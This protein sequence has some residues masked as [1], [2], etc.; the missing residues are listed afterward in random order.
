M[1]NCFNFH[2]YIYV[3]F[4]DVRYDIY[5][6]I[7]FHISSNTHQCGVKLLSRVRLCVT[8]WSVVHQ[9]PLSMGFPRPEYWSGLPFPSPGHLPD[10]SIESVSPA[11]LSLQGFLYRR[12]TTEACGIEGNSLGTLPHLLVNI[13]RSFQIKSINH[14]LRT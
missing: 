8:P 12:A 11:A 9:A 13:K 3:Q 1:Y 7:M 2:I 5:S 4:E 14:H 6:D 10:R